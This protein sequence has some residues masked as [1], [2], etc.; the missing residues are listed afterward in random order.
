M[1]GLGIVLAVIAAGCYVVAARVQH[2][3]VTGATGGGKLTLRRLGRLFRDRGWLLG[4]V[5]LAGGAG[6]HAVSLAYAPIAVVQPIGVL[7]LVTITVVQ[8]RSDRRR[9][10]PGLVAAVGA[11]TTGIAVFVVLA[12]GD[13]TMALPPEGSALVA[14]LGV[15]AVAGGAVAFGT[16]GPRRARCVALGIAGGSCYGLV[17]ALAHIA[18]IQLRFGTVTAALLPGAGM[19]LTALLGGLLVQHAYASGPPDVVMA[20]TTVIDPL[21]AIGIGVLLLGESGAAGPLVVAGETACA[22]L[23]I[24]GVVAMARFRSPPRPEPDAAVVAECLPAGR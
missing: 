17:S 8:A 24:A 19:L 13:S 12:A 11:S 3:A 20:C 15:F 14:T 18:G 4:L 6:L 2:T 7:T 22:V 1:M 21:V 9:L 10:T 16:F 5:T 23:A